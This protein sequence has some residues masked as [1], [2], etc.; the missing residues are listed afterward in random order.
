MF[1]GLIGKKLNMTTS[2]DEKKG[3]AIPVT[4]IELGPCKVT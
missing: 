3:L 1:N 4:I 2:F